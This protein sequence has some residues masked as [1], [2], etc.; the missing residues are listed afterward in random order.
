MSYR[1]TIKTLRT[2][3]A[4]LNTGTGNPVD[5]YRREGDRLISVPGVYVL[6]CA[7][8]GYRL[9]QMVGETGGERD[10]TPRYGAAI[11]ADLIRAYMDGIR[12]GRSPRHPIALD[13]AA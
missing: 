7:Y 1:T 4:T 12:E 13:P 3:V 11:T 6:D 9:A 5:P 2:L 10:I 8:G